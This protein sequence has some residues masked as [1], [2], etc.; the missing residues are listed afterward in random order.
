MARMMSSL[1][2]T[3]LIKEAIKNARISL[4]ALGL[5]GITFVW[6]SILFID[7]LSYPREFQLGKNIVAALAVVAFML[8]ILALQIRIRGT[9]PLKWKRLAT[10]GVIAAVAVI[11]QWFVIV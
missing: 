4:A 10:I 11:L 6:Q 9:L 3:K 7:T 8:L 2:N 5:T 1:G